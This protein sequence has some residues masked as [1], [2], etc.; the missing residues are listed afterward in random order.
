MLINYISVSVNIRLWAWQANPRKKQ[1]RTQKLS[2]AYLTSVVLLQ[3]LFI[4]IYSKIIRII[5]TV[6][7]PQPGNLRLRELK[8]SRAEFPSDEF[9]SLFFATVYEK[10]HWNMRQPEVESIRLIILSN[11]YQNKIYGFLNPWIAFGKMKKIVSTTMLW[12]HWFC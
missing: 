8:Y 5:W 12:N 9:S 1:Q 11:V 3:M 4:I 6:S 7:I 2:S 10:I